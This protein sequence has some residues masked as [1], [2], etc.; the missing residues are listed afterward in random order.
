MLNLGSISLSFRD[1]VHVLTADA[2]GTLKTWDLRTGLCIQEFLNEL[3][4][5]PISHIT[6]TTSS[7]SN[8]NSFK[9]YR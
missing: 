7:D 6:V 1:G 5:K 8:I 3:N 2:L 4:H 9:E